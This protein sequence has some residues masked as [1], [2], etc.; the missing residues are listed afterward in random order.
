MHAR[1]STSVSQRALCTARIKRTNPQQISRDQ[2][3]MYRNMRVSRWAEG[4]PA[5]N[6][7]TSDE[8]LTQT[9]TRAC[10]AY[11]RVVSSSLAVAAAAAAAGVM[12]SRWQ[13]ARTASS[14]N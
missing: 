11:K 9:K 3:I 10:V 12:T 2:L 4:R 6:W 13:D 5:A 8:E 14:A 7:R 1:V